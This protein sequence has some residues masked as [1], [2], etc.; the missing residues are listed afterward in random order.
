MDK[1]TLSL[2]ILC[3]AWFAT[4]VVNTARQATEEEL[5]GWRFLQTGVTLHVIARN[6]D[7][8]G[9]NISDCLTTTTIHK[10]DKNHTAKQI[11]KFWNHAASKWM[12][13]NQGLAAF[14]NEEGMYNTM[15]T[16]E[17]SAGPKMW[18]KF[19]HTR[20][21]CCVMEVGYLGSKRTV[22]KV[23]ET[24]SKEDTNGLHCVLWVKENALADRHTSC[25]Q[26][27]LRNC[28]T[29]HVYTVYNRTECMTS[30][31]GLQRDAGLKNLG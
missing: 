28:V 2:T 20:E 1:A 18:Y 5:D 12:S 13:I 10:N 4:G 15:R 3:A 19:L 6:Y 16:T 11:V 21:S 14:S 17:G 30:Q 25:E 22:L 27:F 31:A 9:N 26:Y 8:L 29:E 24:S 23:K 7:P